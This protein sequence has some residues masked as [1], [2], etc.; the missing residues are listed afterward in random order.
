MIELKDFKAYFYNNIYWVEILNRLGCKYEINELLPESDTKIES[1]SSGWGFD[2]VLSYGMSKILDVETE[3]TKREESSKLDEKP[4]KITEQP[5]EKL[6]NMTEKP[7]NL[8][9]QPDSSADIPDTSG[10]KQANLTNS[11]SN[12]LS[13]SSPTK[14]LGGY[15]R[16]FSKSFADVFTLEQNKGESSTVDPSTFV[17]DVDDNDKPVMQMAS[18][19]RSS[20]F[21]FFD[22]FKKKT[23]TPAFAPNIP[24][25]E[26][27][28]IQMPS[29]ERVVVR[30]AYANK[31]SQNIKIP[32][33]ANREENQ[34]NQKEQNN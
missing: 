8:I 5:V 22:M 26:K 28:P 14:P 29:K 18:G 19:N 12:E 24:K 23:E 32:G 2:R 27:M 11:N 10:E 21:G 9:D 6:N 33:L 1:K 20:F 25:P 31:S 16:A 7:S 13:T 3:D 30:S 4:T 34:V 15:K 17:E